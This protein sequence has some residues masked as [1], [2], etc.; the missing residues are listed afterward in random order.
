MKKIK[1]VSGQT[2]FDIAIQEQGSIEGI[3]DI[4]DL[5]P[6][7]L[8]DKALHAETIVFIPDSIIDPKVVDYLALNNIKPVS[9]IGEEQIITQDDMNNITQDLNYNIAGGEKEFPGVRLFFLHDML[10]VQIAYS[11]ITA[12]TVVVSV[13][14]SLDGVH[15]T[16][17]PYVS[18]VLDKTEQAHTFNIVGLLT[19]F[20]RI[21]ITTPDFSEGT[22]ISVTWKT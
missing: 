21:H 7:M 18:Q 17:I 2:L 3:F 15:W 8:L 9:S 19:D 20:V 16:T 1:A 10:T 12:D 11:D 4:L 22:L 13:D 6:G 14:Q 5:N